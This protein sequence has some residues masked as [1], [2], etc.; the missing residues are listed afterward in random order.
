MLYTV[1]ITSTSPVTG[2]ELISNRKFEASDPT[3]LE[4]IIN[5]EQGESW[6]VIDVESPV[7]RSQDAE[8]AQTRARAK[9]QGRTIQTRSILS[10]AD[11]DA[12]LK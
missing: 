9:R 3:A 12:V 10:A 6:R 4:Q 7:T 1:Q 8:I 5:P 2:R 11:W